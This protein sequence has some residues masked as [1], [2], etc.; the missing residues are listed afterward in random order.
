VEKK[1]KELNAESNKVE[2][3]QDNPN[4]QSSEQVETKVSFLNLTDKLEM[5][6][7]EFEKTDTSRVQYISKNDE[8][9]D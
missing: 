1:Q 4:Q 6:D 7:N 5:I 8:K 9:H 2:K 3:D